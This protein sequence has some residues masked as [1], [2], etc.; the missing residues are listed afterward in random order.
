MGC[1][2]WGN[3][4]EKCEKVPVAFRKNLD[5]YAFSSKNAD[6]KFSASENF[7][8]GHSPRYQCS[9]VLG[10]WILP[11]EC[12]YKMFVKVKQCI[13]QWARSNLFLKAQIFRFS[14]DK[15]WPE[16]NFWPKLSQQAAH[17][18]VVSSIKEKKTAFWSV[19]G[20]QDPKQY[21]LPSKKPNIES[22]SANILPK[23]IFNWKFKK[24]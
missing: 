4:A 15:N 14:T 11:K 16:K 18:K 17:M 12:L 21:R 23:K 22:F 2:T 1:H 13:G 7:S 19:P 6:R 10:I 20:R 8:L 9:Y 3:R 24:S 5:F